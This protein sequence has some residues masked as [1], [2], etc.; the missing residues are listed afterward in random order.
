M[1]YTVHTFIL[2]CPYPR[3]NFLAGSYM[4]IIL[5][6]SGGKTTAFV[7]GGGGKV[8]VGLSRAVAL[9]LARSVIRTG[10]R[11]LSLGGGV[12]MAG[13]GGNAKRNKN[14]VKLEITE[15]VKIST[16][17]SRKCVITNDRAP[18]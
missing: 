14:H 11:R 16:S 18:P 17:Y 1:W 4:S 5:H 7:L 2:P 3:N 13:G 10:P 12:D 9:E 6:G 15:D 8:V